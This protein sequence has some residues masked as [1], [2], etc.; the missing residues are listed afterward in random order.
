MTGTE[1]RLIA[2][3][4]AISAIIWSPELHLD[5]SA[6]TALTT[7]TLGYLA[8]GVHKEVQLA[9]AAKGED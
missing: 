2:F 7:V 6:L 5:G 4:T 8:Q 9:K 1:R 3:F